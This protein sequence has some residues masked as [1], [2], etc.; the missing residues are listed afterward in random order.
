MTLGNSRR[1]VS[2]GSNL[3]TM[4]RCTRTCTTDPCSRVSRV[5]R[6]LDSRLPYKNYFPRTL[7]KILEALDTMESYD[8]APYSY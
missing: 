4:A 5:Q 7:E 3:H 6:A 2:P 8:P 1:S